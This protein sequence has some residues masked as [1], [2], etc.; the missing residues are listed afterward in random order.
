MLVKTVQARDTFW[1]QTISMVK[2]K[3]SKHQEEYA[4]GLR[5]VSDLLW[6]RRLKSASIKEGVYVPHS[7]IRKFESCAINLKRIVG[8]L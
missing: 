6:P 3:G 7:D 4:V 1:N 8:R 2:E 5:Y